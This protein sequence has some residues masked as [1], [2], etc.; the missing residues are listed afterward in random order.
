MVSNRLAWLVIAGAVSFPGIVRTQE[1]SADD[2]KP[3]SSASGQKGPDAKSDEGPKPTAD[4]PPL[5]INGAAELLGRLKPERLATLADMIEQDWPNRPEWAE[6]ALAVMRGQAMQPGAGWWRATEK[7]Y[8]WTWLKRKYDKNSNNIV[9][10]DEF[11]AG[12]P[13]DLF[14]RRLDRDL[15][16]KITTADFDVSVFQGASPS[17]AR[18]R[19]AEFLFFRFDTDTN[20][21]V[22]N[23]EL[24]AFF[25]RTDRE[26]SSFLTAEEIMEALDDG[27]A[28][29]TPSESHGPSTSEQL[30][31]F[32]SG[33]LGWFEE[34][35][36]LGD[37]APDFTL[38]THDQKSSFSLSGSR[39][40][41]PVVIIFGSFT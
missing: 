2:K 25:S 41:K 22:T 15:D 7:K 29:Q 11:P 30:T 34:G 37:V 16:G 3:T 14:L 20:G 12:A 13:S 33:Q 31:M 32:F 28:A 17:A 26:K 38:S 40:K 5:A 35:P 18:A 6:M 19:L 39:D 10:K 4:S 21:Q 23:E 9:E 8:G 24:A 36:K 27:E 1:P